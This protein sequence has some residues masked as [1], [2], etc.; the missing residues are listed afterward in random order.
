[1]SYPSYPDSKNPRSFED[2]LEFQDFVAD[3]LCRELGLAIS[4]FSSRRYQYRFGENKQGIEIKLDR[5]MLE[6]GNVSI[7]VGEKSRASNANYVPSG[8][9]R[10][11]NSWLYVQGNREMF[12][13]FS[14]KRL[15]DLYNTNRYRVDELPTIRRFLMP[16]ADAMKHAEKVMDFRGTQA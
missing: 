15:V 6:T 13:I 12:F 16:L 11:D 7:E 3:T 10:N 4:N 9:L 14:K 5:R 8:I 1:M 2:G